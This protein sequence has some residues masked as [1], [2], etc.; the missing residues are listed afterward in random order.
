MR[1]VKF[2][3]ATMRD[4]LAKV[5]AELGDQ[6]VIVSTR[7]IKRGLLG[8]AACEISAA[9]DEPDANDPPMRTPRFATSPPP[10]VANPNNELELEKAIGPMRS[11]LR[12]L[13]ALV[14]SANDGRAHSEL[15]AEVAALRTLVEKFQQPTASIAQAPSA[16]R[17]PERKPASATGRLQGE[18]AVKPNLAPSNSRIVMI[19]GP[20][21]AGKTTTIAKLAARAALIDQRTVGLVTL[22][23]YRVGGVD[24]IRTFADLI[25]VP[26]QIAASAAGLAEILELDDSEQIYIDTAG[27]SP[28]DAAAINDLVTHL[29]SDIEV[30][31]AIPA[32]IS[33]AMI[34]DLVARY[35]PLQ[36]QR[37][38]F[39]KLDEV[40]AA[41]ELLHAPLRTRLPLTY[42]TTGQAVPEDLEE[43]TI[44]RV[45]EIANRGLRA[46]VEAA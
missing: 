41:P 16:V 17:I 36:P 25:G 40:G 21:G 43:P 39:T 26:L 42:I 28:R 31:L 3:G 29:T 8:G 27:R 4:A 15:R 37:L 10:A 34:D 23:H 46:N 6:A 7:Q 12:S 18:G 22:D 13:R 44:A 20:T 5:K 24:Q 2:E 35:A 19:V 33:G 38:L 9:T 32:T 1:I 14:R 45:L 11:E 30:H